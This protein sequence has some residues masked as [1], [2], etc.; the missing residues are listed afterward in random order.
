M[1]HW[2]VHKALFCLPHWY[3]PKSLLDLLS[4]PGPPVT[5]LT[6]GSQCMAEAGVAVPISLTSGPKLTSIPVAKAYS[7]HL[8]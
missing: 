7:A 3:V 5:S 8:Q 2:Y 4:T 1:P 6:P